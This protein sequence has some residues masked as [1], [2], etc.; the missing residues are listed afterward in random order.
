LT[1]TV[2]TPATAKIKIA[3]VPTNLFFMTIISIALS[4]VSAQSFNLK[5][6]FAIVRSKCHAKI[7]CATSAVTLLFSRGR[8]DFFNGRSGRSRNRW[9]ATA[10][11][12][13]FSQQDG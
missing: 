8:I 3:K 10:K 1:L 12:V 7:Q 5:E 11:V 2:S 9:L 13:V 6:R 4:S